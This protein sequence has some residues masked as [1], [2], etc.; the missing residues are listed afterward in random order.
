MSWRDY[1]APWK[2]TP[3]MI[4]TFMRTIKPKPK[5]KPEPPPAPPIEKV[6]RDRMGEAFGPEPSGDIDDEGIF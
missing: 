2:L 5:A 3:E 4:E 1:P 6:E